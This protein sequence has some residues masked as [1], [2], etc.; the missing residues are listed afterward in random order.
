MTFGIEAWRGRRAAF[1]GDSITESVGSDKAYH[2]YLS[3]WLGIEAYNY[4]VNGA[5]TDYML[6]LA[7]RLEEE[8]PDVDAVFVFGGTND[9]NHG[10]PMGQFYTAGEDAVNHN[11]QTVKRLH[12][13]LVMDEG[14]FCGRLNRLLGELKRGFPMAQVIVMTPIHRGFARFSD[15]N[16]QPDELW[17]NAQG[18]FIGDYAEA[19]RQAARVWSAPLIDLYTGCG[20]LPAFG[21]YAP[22]FYDAVTDNLH[23]NA[24]GHERIARTI[25]AALNA[26]PASV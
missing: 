23:P 17:A 2:E 6:A 13:A 14:T 7:K 11:G 22:F 18:L 26:I 16:V 1:I 20:L 15:E 4:G 3:E 9:F 10:L 5:Q 19:V 21:E 25:A 8:H 12:R 24:R